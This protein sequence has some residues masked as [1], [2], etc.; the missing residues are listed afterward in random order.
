[1]LINCKPGCVGKKATTEASLDVDEDEVVCSFCGEFLE[2]SS[3]TKTSMK[4]R[5]DIVR[6]NTKSSFQ[7]DCLTCNK[8]VETK[9]DGVNLVGTE[10]KKGGC[11]FNVSK[12]T[13]HA[14]KK[15]QEAL[16]KQ[17]EN[18]SGLSTGKI[19]RRS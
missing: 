4:Q 8:S 16:K 9:V 17:D 3:F 19:S 15:T 14:I 6:K 18:N 1:M 12:F 5:G 11:K 2:V 10:C 7:Y 13:V